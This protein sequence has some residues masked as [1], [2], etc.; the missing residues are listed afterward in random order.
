MPWKTIFE[1]SHPQ[2]GWSE[3]YWNNY[4]SDATAAYNSALVLAQERM[5]LSATPTVM[6]YLRLSDA[7]TSRNASITR[8]NL[9][10]PFD[11]TS[12]SDVG[13]NSAM[14]RLYAG[15]SGYNRTVYVRGIPDDVYDLD[16][17]GNTDENNWK[18]HF[19]AHYKQALIPG[20]SGQKWFVRSR[21]RETSNPKKTIVVIAPNTLN[22]RLEFDYLPSDTGPAVGDYVVL[23]G[24]KGVQ[25]APGLVKVV[26]VDTVLKRVVVDYVLPR[27]YTFQGSPM[28]RNY[29]VKYTLI[30]YASVAKITHRIIGRPFGLSRGR[31]VAIPRRLR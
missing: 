26:G 9:T 21:N 10:C 2:G 28:W 27:N 22:G 11:Y 18:N 31:R 20:G 4:D 14:V 25:P 5:W 24:V 23:Y 13:Y 15:A 1:F 3:T 8:V 17:T 30:D 12:D 29:L 6:N 7:T 19:E 16:S